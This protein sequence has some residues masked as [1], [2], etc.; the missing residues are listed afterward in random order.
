MNLTLTPSHKWPIAP[1]IKETTYFPNVEGDLGAKYKYNLQEAILDFE[2]GC[3]KA[4]MGQWGF[5]QSYDDKLS[6]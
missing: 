4:G 1:F 2:Q 5:V 6:I 3:E